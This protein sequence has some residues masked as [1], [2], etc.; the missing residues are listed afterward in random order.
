[1]T[2]AILASLCIAQGI[3]VVMLA[4]RVERLESRIARYLADYAQW[5]QRHGK[6]AMSD[7]DWR[8]EDWCQ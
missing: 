7:E 5:K 6:P 4:R 8:D 1:M 2:T 3:A